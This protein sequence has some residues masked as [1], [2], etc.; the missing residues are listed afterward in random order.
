MEAFENNK[1]KNIT[2]ISKYSKVSRRNDIEDY[3]ATLIFMGIYRL[4]NYKNFWSNALIL[5][6]L[7][8]NSVKI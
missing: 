2:M 5:G 1:N 6:S 7:Y 3:F 8:K 4:P